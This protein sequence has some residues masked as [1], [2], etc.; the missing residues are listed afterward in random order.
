VLSW[1]KPDS[2]KKIKVKRQKCRKMKS[3]LFTLDRRD[4][5]NGLLIAFL[6][7]MIDGIIKILESGVI[8]DW[9]HLRPVVIAGISAALS[10]L[11]KS[12]AT[13]SHNQLF[14]PEP[15]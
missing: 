9:P 13:N 8:F 15:A 4:L 10:Y 5:M 12:P 2:R 7:A 14:K 1:R 3:K 6:A 11:F